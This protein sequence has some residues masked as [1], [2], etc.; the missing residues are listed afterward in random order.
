MRPIFRPE[1]VNDP[2]GDPGLYVDFKFEN[3]ALLFDLGDLT[4]LPSKKILRISDVFV[5]HTHMDHFFGFDRL[6]RLCLGRPTS[7]RLYGPPGFAAQVEHKLAAYTWNLVE[8]YPGDFFIDT[9]E[10]DSRWHARGIRMRCRQRFQR[11]PLEARHFPNGVLLDEPAF[12]VRAALLDHGIACLGFAV[13]EKV[14]VNVWKN[15]LAELGLGVGPWLKD[16]KDAV[17]RNAP[18]E[19]PVR[20]WWR[21]GNDMHERVLSLGPLKA[22]ILRLVPG[23]KI[24][25]VTDVAFNQDNA[26][27]IAALA[28]DATQLFIECVFLD[29]DADHAA[30]KLHLTAGQA[31][32]IARAAGAKLVI[33]FHFSARYSGRDAELRTEVQAAWTGSAK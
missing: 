19:T 32:N 5:S 8:N 11:E 18:D 17:A 28:A 14:H 2:F 6:L 15:R 33:P 29:Q 31:G 1:L 16:L 20:A 24:C 7:V 27:R 26:K 4:S 30:R 9:W 21:D 23:E 13:E 10:V 25:Y 12:C 22:A 3:R